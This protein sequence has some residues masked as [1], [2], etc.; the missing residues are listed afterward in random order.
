MKLNKKEIELFGIP[1]KEKHMIYIS[2]I[3]CEL[4]YESRDL[5]STLV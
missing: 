4:L 5:T 3:V 2:R 1:K